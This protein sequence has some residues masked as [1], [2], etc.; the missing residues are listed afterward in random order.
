MG[1][2]AECVYC[3]I[4]PFGLTAAAALLLRRYPLVEAVGGKAGPAFRTELA[5]TRDLITEMC[6]FDAY[7]NCRDTPAQVFK[8]SFHMADV[9]GDDYVRS[10]FYLSYRKFIENN[11]AE[12]H[13]KPRKKGVKVGESRWND[14]SADYLWLSQPSNR[15]TS[16][17]RTRELA[18]VV[19]ARHKTAY[20][21]ANYTNWSLD[22]EVPNT[23]RYN[24]IQREGRSQA[25]LDTIKRAIGPPPGLPPPRLPPPR[26]PPP[27]LPSNR[28]LPP[29]IFQVPA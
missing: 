28:S 7:D 13:R 18:E 8:V 4:N 11:F 10:Q 27:G 6:I 23:R 21:L 12:I 29:G 15:R 2:D 16:I 25:R 26:L 3:M 19:L 1:L 20:A 22:M 9:E 5:K 14:E 24:T 17:T